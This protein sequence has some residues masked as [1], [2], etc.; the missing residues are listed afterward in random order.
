MDNN[1]RMMR[2]VTAR[3][4]TMRTTNNKGDDNDEIHTQ[5]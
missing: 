3:M 2:M 5:Q 1:M 4:M